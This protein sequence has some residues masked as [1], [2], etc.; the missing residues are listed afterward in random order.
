MVTWIDATPTSALTTKGNPANEIG[1]RVERAELDANGAPGIWGVLP[2]SDTFVAIPGVVNATTGIP[3]NVSINA[4]ANVESFKD[5]TIDPAISYAYRVVAV[6][7]AVP[8]MSTGETPSAHTVLAAL[9]APGIPVASLITP[10]SL[11]LSWQDNAKNE[12]NYTVEYSNDG[13]VTWLPN[14]AIL[15]AKGTVVGGTLSL[16]IMGLTPG[17]N[18]I[19]RVSAVRGGKVNLTF[20]AKSGSISTPAELKAPANLIST[21]NTVNKSVSLTWKDDSTA[22]T[23]YEVQRATGKI[24]GTTGMVTWGLPASLPTAISL[25]AANL[26]TYL[27]S[28]TKVV[29]NTL[30]QYQ[31]K[32]VSGID[33]SPFSKVS[34]ATA[35]T[36]AAVTQPQLSGAATASTLGIQWQQTTSALATG[37]EVQVC[38]GLAAV[39]KLAPE[40]SWMAIPPALVMSANNTKYKATGLKSKTSYTFRVRAINS[41]IL[42]L[43]SPWAGYLSAKT[44]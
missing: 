24:S 30:Y 3:T 44:L 42:T 41:E 11:T 20:S 38:V 15:V 6:N 13:G 23:G 22:E 34:A 9:V 19:F 36:L 39:C 29:A 10:R 35:T 4:L 14:S 40:T 5:T 25:L 1:F 21:Y 33:S 37:Y 8:L 17:S 43:V 32:A 7:Q 27:D 31:V 12:D 16:P 28:G 26:G 2:T 18:Y